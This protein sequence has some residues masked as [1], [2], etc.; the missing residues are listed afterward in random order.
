MSQKYLGMLLA[1]FVLATATN[2]TVRAGED[3]EGGKPKKDKAEKEA[4]KENDRAAED[5]RR[6]GGRGFGGRD[7]GGGAPAW[8]GGQGGQGG[9]FGGLT[10]RGAGGISQMVSR[11]L[12]IE[13]EDPK[14]T[15]KVDSLPL[16]ADKRLVLK[17]P[18]GGVDNP[19]GTGEG[20]KME[21]IFKMTEEQTKSVDVLR[22]EYKVE[23]KKLDQEILDMQK[24][25]AEKVKLLR[26]KYELRA[27]DV[28][29]GEDKAS[30]EKMDALAKELNTKNTAIVTET[31]PLYD[32]NDMTQS[33][34]MIRA[35]REKTAANVK[36]AETKLVELIP[37]ENRAK[38]QDVL[39]IQSEERERMTRWMTPRNREVGQPGEARPEGERKPEGER[40][41]RRGGGDPVKP[42]RPPETPPGNGN[43]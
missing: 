22:E 8:G 35:I 17:V 32:A 39:K 3:A 16:G 19:S 10:N 40:R 13:V 43:F 18:V 24:A 41:E 29:T 4:Q 26:S 14:A 20:W 38:I 5:A 34:A 23:Q 11:M 33:L 9:P 1:G 12:G 30:K 36:E 42:P 15:V 25:I 27:N 21:N 6:A 31:M 37:A 28:L 2:V 7:G